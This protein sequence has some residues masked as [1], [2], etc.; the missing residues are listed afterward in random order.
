MVNGI[1]IQKYKVDMHTFFHYIEN[2]KYSFEQEFMISPGIYID[3]YIPLVKFKFSHSSKTGKCIA[4]SHYANQW[5]IYPHIMFWYEFSGDIPKYKLLV[6]I[7]AGY[8]FHPVNSFWVMANNSKAKVQ[9]GKS[10]KWNQRGVKMVSIPRNILIF[11]ISFLPYFRG[12]T[13]C[14]Y[15]A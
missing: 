3:I 1:Y 8:I 15:I 14:S 9:K 11:H 13:Y 12:W 6:T 2:D 10:K 4:V 5:S 7:L